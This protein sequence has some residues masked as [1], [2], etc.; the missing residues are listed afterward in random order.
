MLKI[1]ISFSVKSYRSV[2]LSPVFGMVLNW[3][4]FLPPAGC[5]EYLSVVLVLVL[6]HPGVLGSLGVFVLVFCSSVTGDTPRRCIHQK[7]TLTSLSSLLFYLFHLLF[8]LKTLDRSI[9]F[10]ALPFIIL[11]GVFCLHLCVCVCVCV[12]LV[13]SWPTPPGPPFWPR[14]CCLCPLLFDGFRCL[15]FIFSLDFF[16]YF[17]PVVFVDTRCWAHC[18]HFIDY[19]SGWICW[20]LN[21]AAFGPRLGSLFSALWYHSY[22]PLASLIGFSVSVCL[23]FCGS[24]YF[25]LFGCFRF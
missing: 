10:L 12:D 4:S 2:L 7:F 1:G 23:L 21:S 14:P 11:S 17:S 16:S 18:R 3:N 13:A 24:L 25:C 8:R 9:D 20:F 6:V 19:F 5:P 22:A 15:P